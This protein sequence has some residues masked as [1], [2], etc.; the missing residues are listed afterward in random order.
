M[1]RL[2]LF[3]LT[4]LGITVALPVRAGPEIPEAAI[5][6]R[7]SLAGEKKVRYLLRQ[8]DLTEEQAT[9]ARGLI[10]SILPRRA[11]PAPPDPDEVRRTWAELEQAKETGDQEKVDA[12]VKQLR[13]MGRETTGDSE[14]FM[15]MEPLL[16]DEQKHKLDQARARLERNPSGALRPVDLLRAAR[17]LDL[18]EQ[19]QRQLLD[20]FLEARKHLGP[21]LRPSTELK[22][23]M[24]N[25]FAH[26]IR[27]FLT[28]EQL[29]KFEY[30]IRALRPDLLDRGLRV[31]LSETAPDAPPAEEELKPVGD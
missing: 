2:S 3:A 9:H 7:A 5:D 1:C 11:R 6:E 20:A 30:R 18:T 23:Q 17:E 26:E 21:N 19:Q 27:T 12:L 31:Q 14:F 4:A 13:Q 10:D 8:V 29:A 16:T 15:N 22:L 28:P 24:I 25:F